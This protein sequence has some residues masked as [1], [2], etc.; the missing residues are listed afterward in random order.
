MKIVFN[1]GKT[2][3]VADNIVVARDDVVTNVIFL[4]ENNK[5]DD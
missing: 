2:F 4:A 3:P 5:K 1:H